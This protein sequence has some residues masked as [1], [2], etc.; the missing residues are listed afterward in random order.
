MYI[1][2]VFF[3]VCLQS[4]QLLETLVPGS[5]RSSANGL[6]WET[7]I[8]QTPSCPLPL[9]TSWL[10]PYTSLTY[11]TV[12]HPCVGV[13][14]FCRSPQNFGL[15]LNNW[16]ST[17]MYSGILFLKFA[18]SAF[19]LPSSVYIIS[20]SITF[21]TLLSPITRS[22]A[23]YFFTLECT[24]TVWRPGSVPPS[25]QLASKGEPHNRERLG[26]REED[27]G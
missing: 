23:V 11:R 12:A 17:L 9:T 2:F 16:L 18:T 26:Q 4:L 21:L 20:S 13:V 14:P 8:S 5:H 27:A 7:S 3:I 19:I 6:R 1:R 25:P 24:K 22:L 10:R 15:P